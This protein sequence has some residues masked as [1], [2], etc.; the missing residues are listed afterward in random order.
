MWTKPYGQTGKNV[1]VVSFG[2]MRFGDPQDH[3]ANAQI[4]LHAF[5]RGINYFD[6][7]P[8]YCG[9][10]SEDIMGAAFKHMP[11]DKFYCATKC[12][13]AEG[14]KF[15]E[16]L[17]RSLKRLGV[18]KI[19]FMHIWCLVAPESWQQRKAGGAVAAARKA[20]EEG[21]V[22]HVV[23]SV[24][25]SGE[26][27]AD[28]LDA[29]GWLEG[30]TIGYNAV[31]FPFRGKA[32]DAARDHNI[33]V[34]TMNPLGGGLIPT[35]AQRLD[36]LRAPGDRSVVEAAIRFNVSHPAIT[37]ALVGFSTKEQ[38]DE[39]VAAVENF[40]AYPA[41]HIEKIKAQIGTAF[42][43]LCTMCGYCTGCPVDVPITKYMDSYN[44]QILGE[45]D[46]GIL[47]RLKW[48]WWMAPDQAAAC[49]QCGICEEK[50][51]QHL[52]IRERLEHI[53]RLKKT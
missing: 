35:H 14:A 37:S 28:L 27:T 12:M 19:D 43:G 4:V 44:Y 15:R 53:A 25:L 41:E 6:T 23:T 24:H 21:L 29:E 49:T 17:E 31:N 48:H 8:W 52:P 39:A 33:G 26:E 16:S 7:A 45:G 11:R 2:G 51:T 47:D 20:K 10:H 18:E 13:E 50:C 9:D 42:E 22:A 1:S 3:D 34:V 38:V 5:Q 36:F 40:R 30:L 46:Q 32:L